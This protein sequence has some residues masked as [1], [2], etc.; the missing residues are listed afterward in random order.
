MSDWGEDDYTPPPS[1][2]ATMGNGQLFGLD[3][4]GLAGEAVEA[5]VKASVRRQVAE[6]A[7][8]AAQE[9][10]TPELIETLRARAAQAAQAVVTEQ[11]NGAED[12][13]D[14]STSEAEE[15]APAQPYYGSVDEFVREYLRHVYRRAINGRSRIWAA[16]WWEYDEVVIRLEALWRAWEFL[17]LDPATGMSVWFRD[18]ADPHMT[19]LMDPDGPFAAADANAEN[20]HA[21]KG[22]PLPYEAPPEGLFPDVRSTT[23]SST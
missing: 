2:T 12:E 14:N 20:N 11:V 17:R 15:P 6:V 22:Q 1:T 13:A 19:V 18:H 10:L 21:R 16:R 8:D 4:G 7:A 5:A 23:S 9:A 3:I